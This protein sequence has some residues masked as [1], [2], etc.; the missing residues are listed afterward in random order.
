M[1]DIH[2]VPVLLVVDAV[3]IKAN[4]LNDAISILKD[5][6]PNNLKA[7]WQDFTQ[8]V[9]ANGL[10]IAIELGAAY[11]LSPGTVREPFKIAGHRVKLW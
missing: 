6:S 1:K 10:P 5:A 4:A 11:L 2:L 7:A 9:Q 8:N 3:A